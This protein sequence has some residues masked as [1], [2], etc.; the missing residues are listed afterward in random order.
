[1]LIITRTKF[2]TLPGNSPNA[3]HYVA[4]V[5][6]DGETFFR[7]SDTAAIKPSIPE[8]IRKGTIFFYKRKDEYSE[9]MEL[10]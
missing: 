8:D 3:G 2:L 1:M 4:H 6:L 9:A 5:T 10:W 7:V